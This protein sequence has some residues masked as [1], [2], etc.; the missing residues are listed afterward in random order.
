[1]SRSIETVRDY[2]RDVCLTTTS[3]FRQDD[4]TQLH[5]GGIHR[6]L[7]YVAEQGIRTV[8]PC[9]NTGEFHALTLEECATVTRGNRDGGRF[10]LLRYQR[11]RLHSAHGYCHGATGSRSRRRRP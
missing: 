10:R 9:G 7:D 11:H 8:A 2:L 5:E 4:I 6:N 1:M 3:P